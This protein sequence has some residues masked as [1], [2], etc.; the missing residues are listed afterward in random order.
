MLAVTPPL[1]LDHMQAFM[2]SCPIVVLAAELQVQLWLAAPRRPQGSWH[3]LHDRSAQVR[4]VWDD[5]RYRRVIEVLGHVRACD[6]LTTGWASC[7]AKEIRD[8]ISGILHVI[9]ED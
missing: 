6:D 1:Q 4:C 7:C 3:A 8:A 2:L 9:A 5:M